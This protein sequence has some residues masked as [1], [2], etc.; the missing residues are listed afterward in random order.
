MIQEG[1]IGSSQEI[2]C[3]SRS[4]RGSRKLQV[5]SQLNIL[6]RYKQRDGSESQERKEANGWEVGREKNE[7]RRTPPTPKSVATS[8]SPPFKDGLICRMIYLM[9]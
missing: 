3:G 5:D 4:L 2:R 9:S 8:V 7:A 1:V 6:H